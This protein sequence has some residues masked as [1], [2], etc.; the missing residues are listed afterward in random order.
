MKYLITIFCMIMLSRCSTAPKTVYYRVFYDAP[1]NVQAEQTLPFVLALN[2]LDASP[3][4]SQ[5]NILH[6]TSDV[7]LEY[8]PYNQWESSPVKTVEHALETAFKLS[9]VFKGVTS[10]RLITNSDLIL[11]GRLTKFEQVEK[12]SSY[13]AEIELEYELMEPTINRIVTAGKINKQIT[14]KFMSV[15]SVTEAMSEA[16]TYVINHI[17]TDVTDKATKLSQQPQ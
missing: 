12:F 7:G 3:P 2:K 8:D 4:L 5:P 10:K 6:R 9:H 16:L 13:L 15:E 11:S 14:A 1:V 17:V